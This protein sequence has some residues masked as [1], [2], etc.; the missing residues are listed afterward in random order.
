M[1]GGERETLW[2]P[3][4]LHLVPASDNVDDVCHRIRRAYAP[5][6][7]CGNWARPIRVVD[8]VL[9]L[10]SDDSASG[11]SDLAAALVCIV[12]HEGGEVIATSYRICPTA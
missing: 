6:A 4:P 2:R 9:E 7:V 12:A 5:F 8:H 10:R 11:L 1:Q 3:V